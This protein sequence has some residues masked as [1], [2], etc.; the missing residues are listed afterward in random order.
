MPNNQSAIKDAEVEDKEHTLAELEAAYKEH[1]GWLIFLQKEPM[2]N[3][4]HNKPRYR[5][6]VKNMGLQ[7]VW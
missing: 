1:A 4:L 3:F 2:F 7:P 6:I 5:A